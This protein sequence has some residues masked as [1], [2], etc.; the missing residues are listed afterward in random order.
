MQAPAVS[1]GDEG[2][3]E[4][5]SD[6]IATGSWGGGACVAITRKVIDASSGGHHRHGAC[7]EPVKAVGEVAAFDHTETTM[8]QNSTNTTGGNVGAA[9]ISRT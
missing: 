6:L 4:W 1:R 7:G 2:E 3:I 9:A 5:V 8:M